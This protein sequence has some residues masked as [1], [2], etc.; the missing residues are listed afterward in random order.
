MGV[1]DERI[2]ETLD[3]YHASQY[4][5]QLVDAMPARVSTKQRAKYLARFKDLLWNGGSGHIVAECRALFK[6]PNQLVTRSIN[7]LEK[8][9]NK[10]RYMDYEKQKLMCGSGIIESGIRRIINLRFKNAATFWDKKTVEKLYCLRGVLL[11]K[12]WDTFIHNVA[13]AA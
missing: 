12:R 1:P 6:K 7:Y 5:H 10:T 2:V 11:S 3:Y 13:A 9:E 8:H 4:V